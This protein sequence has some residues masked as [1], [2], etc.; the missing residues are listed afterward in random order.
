MKKSITAGALHLGSQTESTK[1]KALKELLQG[2]HAFAMSQLKDKFEKQLDKLRLELLNSKNDVVKLKTDLQLKTQEITRLTKDSKKLNSEISKKNSQLNSVN[3]QISQKN[4]QVSSLQSQISQKSSQVNSLRSQ[5]N[6]A[7][8]NVSYYQKLYNQ[9]QSR[10][11]TISATSSA[12]GWKYI[13]D[14]K[15]IA[16]PSYTPSVTVQKPKA[17]IIHF[18]NKTISIIGYSRQGMMMV[19]NIN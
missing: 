18:A 6:N 10:I 12:A 16:L 19:K 11:K 2:E 13:A 3:S 15:T 4:S 14:G 17:A 1:E 9:A 8:S 5:L 7:N